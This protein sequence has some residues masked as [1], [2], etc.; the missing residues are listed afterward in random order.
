MHTKLVNHL[1]VSFPVSANARIP[2]DADSTLIKQL[3]QP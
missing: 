2:D 1:N 3:T